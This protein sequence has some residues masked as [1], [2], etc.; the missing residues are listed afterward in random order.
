MPVKRQWLNFPTNG[1]RGQY[2]YYDENASSSLISSD[3]LPPNLDKFN[4]SALYTIV[5]ESLINKLVLKY[6]LGALTD[7]Q[8]KINSLVVNNN[9]VSLPTTKSTVRIWLF[10]SLSWTG[11]GNTTNPDVANYATI[12][13]GL[14][15]LP[16]SRI[17]NYRRGGEIKEGKGFGEVIRN[18][19]II[20]D[21]VD[22]T[23]ANFELQTRGAQETYNTND[24]FAPGS[25]NGV[26]D[27]TGTAQ[28]IYFVIQTFGQG[29]RKY[30]R[31]KKRKAKFT[32]FKIPIDE[33]FDGQ[34]GKVTT[35]NLEP[36][37][38]KDSGGKYRSAFKVDTFEVFI[39]S[40][41]SE[42]QEYPDD[43]FGEDYRW[44]NNS[45]VIPNYNYNEIQDIRDDIGFPTKMNL[46]NLFK[47]FRTQSVSNEIDGHKFTTPDVD[48][49]ATFDQFIQTNFEPVARVNI[50]GNS[51]YE[52]SAFQLD[53]T[54]RQICSAPNQVEL[55]F[56]IS[57]YIEGD[58]ELSETDGTELSSK[59][60]YKFYVLDWNDADNK[61][62]SVEDYLTDIPQDDTEMLNKQDKNLYKFA[63]IYETLTH[64]YSTPGMKIIKAVLFSHLS[65]FG[66]QSFNQ[67]Q[68]VRW[69]FIEIRIFLD[70]P[71][72][73]FPDFGE[74]GGQDF[75]TIPW[76]YTTPII[77]GVSE[78]SK[79]NI[80]VQNTLSGGKLGENEI[81]DIR[82][83]EE[84]NQNDELGETIQKMDLQQVRYFTDG[85]LDMSALL[86]IDMIPQYE[87]EI[88]V[89][90]LSEPEM[91]DGTDLWN[92][93]PSKLTL[94]Y[95]SELT[96]YTAHTI[97]G[98]GNNG[99]G[100][101]MEQT[102]SGLYDHNSDCDS[103]SSCTDLMDVMDLS[104]WYRLKFTY[105]GTEI[106]VGGDGALGAVGMRF[107]GVPFTGNNQR[108]HA[109]NWDRENGPG[110]EPP[111][112]YWGTEIVHRSG[113]GDLHFQIY[114]A[115]G[116][117][118]DDFFEQANCT[119]G[120]ECVIW[121]HLTPSITGNTPTEHMITLHN[122][123]RY[124]RTKWKNMSLQRADLVTQQLES[125]FIP[126][127]DTDYWDCR[128]WDLD[129]NYCFSE[130]S[131]VGQIFIGDNLDLDLKQKC[132]LE[133]NLGEL[134][135]KA[136]ND[137]NGN[138]NKGIL[139]GDYKVKKR[140]KNVRLRRDSFIKLPKKGTSDGAL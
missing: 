45:D 93:N 116:D 71:I 57:D 73:K 111:S 14:K 44:G 53:E 130:E 81:I 76:P 85:Y 26:F 37:N 74:L 72:T 129:R 16:T 114:S 98:T 124:N 102:I 41:A 20:R 22:R 139:I 104:Q 15:T 97:G 117:P 7:S 42:T 105:M 6:G 28:D 140:Q 39:D 21:L 70:I 33:L 84:A 88:P 80:S 83:L 135:G 48:G 87:N 52:L 108:I 128:D 107:E 55:G 112:P 95:D 54:S 99:R 106:N 82:F 1:K 137:T 94:E 59:E 119:I 27:V 23:T 75:T 96:E 2:F 120:E 36:V 8:I 110:G 100:E 127:T 125:I 34:N 46:R 77:N 49:N 61:F 90:F 79:Y 5:Q 35:L 24:S 62:I 64:N 58:G 132:A 69:K 31:D 40:A 56:Y 86:N 101:Y 17:F 134:D 67:S 3:S 65:E 13:N 10:D 9:G 50:T 131:S 115:G 126:Y 109:D 68:I 25:G 18:D 78:N 123:K 32:V 138:P 60:G 12:S 103:F 92:Y 113:T 47:D 118:R 43:I 121:I 122:G 63:D 51:D 136:L 29:W 30:R 19:I 4:N 38:V 133:L 91:S 11:A 89:E 66:T